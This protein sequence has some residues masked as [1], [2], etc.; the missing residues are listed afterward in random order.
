MT[1][2]ISF[3]RARTATRRLLAASCPRQTCASRNVKSQDWIRIRLG[4][5]VPK[6]LSP[7]RLAPKIRATETPSTR[8]ALTWIQQGH[9]SHDGTPG[10]SEFIYILENASFPGVV[11]IGRTEREVADRVKELSSATGVPTEFSLF[12]QYAVDDATITER[13]IHERLAEYRVS[14]NREFFRLS[15]DEAASVLEELLG[16]DS[17]RFPDYDREDE[18]F[19]AATQIAISL[20]K[21]EWPGVLAGPL[22]IS[23]EEA[24]RL[25]AGLQARGILNNQKELCGD[26]QVEHER[27]VRE[28]HSKRQAEKTEKI[29]RAKIHCQMIRQVKE[30]LADLADPETGEAAEVSFDN[31]NGNLVVAVRGTE[32]VRLEAQRRL[33]ELS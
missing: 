6:T 25:I 3:L 15:A 17:Q 10:M 22:K 8:V 16:K 33:S 30:L 13:Q 14:G 12:R 21:I 18:L 11:K 23:H 27:R 28:A 9:S 31:D 4:H 32:W 7:P 20:G 2:R 19:F 1:S 29:T 24:F 5:G 26:L